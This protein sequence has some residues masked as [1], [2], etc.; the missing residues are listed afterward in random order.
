MKMTIFFLA[1]SIYGRDDSDDGFYNSRQIDD[2]PY[3][4]GCERQFFI[5]MVALNQHLFHSLITGVS[6]VLATSSPK[7][8]FCK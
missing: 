4:N 6:N 3:C 5:D 7:P 8:P 2:N 1:S